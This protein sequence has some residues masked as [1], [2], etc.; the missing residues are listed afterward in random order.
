M[1]RRIFAGLAFPDD[2]GLVAAGAEDVAV[3]AVIGEIGFAADEPFG[4]GQIPL[5]DLVPRL[6]PVQL[7]GGV[8]PEGFGIL[9]GVLVEGLVLFQALDMGALC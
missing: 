3:K 1:R 8:G 4:P 9:N 2:G 7:F 6:E 5:E